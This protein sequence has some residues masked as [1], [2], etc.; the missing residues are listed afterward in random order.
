M[1]VHTISSKSTMKARAGVWTGI[2][3][4][5]FFQLSVTCLDE[6]G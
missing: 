4:L 5:V 2:A 6:G 1:L 3:L